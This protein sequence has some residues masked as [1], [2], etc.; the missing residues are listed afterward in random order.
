MNQHESQKASL[1]TKPARFFNQCVF[2][3]LL[4][5]LL[6]IIKLND[7]AT[8]NAHSP[9][10]ALLIKNVISQPQ[11]VSDASNKPLHFA[12]RQKSSRRH[13]GDI[14]VFLQKS[15][16]CPSLLSSRIIKPD[17]HCGCCE[18]TKAS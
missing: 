8:L 14:S 18:T 17:S 9:Q 1:K 3:F 2:F 12:R 10:R 13:D 15:Q 7:D 4:L 11:E 5:L 16:I 6:R